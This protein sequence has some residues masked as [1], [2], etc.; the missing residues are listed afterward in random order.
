MIRKDSYKINIQ[1]G[2]YLLVFHKTIDIGFGSAVSVYINN[3]EYL[4]FDCFGFEKGHYHIY[5]NVNNEIIYFSEKT[6]EEQINRIVFE[7]TNNINLYLQ[8]SNKKS[9]KNFIINMVSL[10]NKIDEMKNKMLE[11]ESTFYSHLR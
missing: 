3:F 4:K 1:Y 5:D 7:L 2:L 6:C 8:K 11:Y 9:I 10:L